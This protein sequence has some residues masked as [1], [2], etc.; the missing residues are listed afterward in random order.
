M[1]EVTL[2]QNALDI[3]EQQAKQSG[4]QRVTAVWLELSAVSC[5]EED[6]LHFCFDIVCRDSLAEGAVLHVTTV[7]AQA[8]CRDCQK[9]VSV[10]GFNTGCPHCGSH[11]LQVDSS[12]AMQVRQIEIQ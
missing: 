7:P 1:H 5:I 2:C 6:A 4:A 8:W 10:S 3:I 9:P 11:N 12:D